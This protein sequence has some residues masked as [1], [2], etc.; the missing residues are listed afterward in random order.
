[1]TLRTI[2]ANRAA[3][4][5]MIQVAVQAQNRLLFFYGI[6][7]TATEVEGKMEKLCGEIKD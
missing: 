4:T 3:V 7:D 2:K 5:Q 6:D 1:M